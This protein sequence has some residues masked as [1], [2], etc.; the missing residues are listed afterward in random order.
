MSPRVQ[1]APVLVEASHEDSV[2]ERRL[3]SGRSLVVRVDGAG[4]EIEIRSARGEMDVRIT[5][6]D[7]GPVIAVRGA[8]LELESPDVAVRCRTFDVHATE[9]LSLS[10]DRDVRI[11][12]DEVRAETKQDIHLNG[13]FIRLNCTADAEPPEAIFARVAALTA[14]AG[15]A[16]APDAHGHE[17]APG[18]AANDP[19]RGAP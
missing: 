3:P 1:T 9:G 15:E 5:L 13:A 8:R 18:P 2:V 12:A 19:S 6:T 11:Q 7:A 14:A 17:H 16:S 10:S 4:E